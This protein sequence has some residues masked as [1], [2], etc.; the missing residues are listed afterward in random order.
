VKLDPLKLCWAD[1]GEDKVC[2]RLAGHEGDHNPDPSADFPIAVR[3]RV[4]PE[5]VE[6]LDDLV[7]RAQALLRQGAL[8]TWTCPH[9][10]MTSWN[11]M[12]VASHYCGNCHHFCDYVEEEKHM[13]EA[14]RTCATNEENEWRCADCPDPDNSVEHLLL[15][16]GYNAGAHVREAIRRGEQH[17]PYRVC[18][19]L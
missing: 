7:E 3:P 15:G 5:D 2:E 4:P 14:D 8:A 13:D 18:P 17:R 12:D 19:N 9:C 1:L 10:E 16:D 11:P 6:G